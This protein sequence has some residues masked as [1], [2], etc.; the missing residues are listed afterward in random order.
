MKN[1]KCYS[2]LFLFIFLISCDVRFEIKKLDNGNVYF[3]QGSVEGVVLNK[4][5]KEENFDELEIKL[6]RINDI[7]HSF[8]FG[9]N[10]DKL[11]KE[12]EQVVEKKGKSSDLVKLYNLSRGDIRDKFYKY[13]RQYTMNLTGDH[14]NTGR[15]VIVFFDYDFRD[16]LNG[17]VEYVT[18]LGE[19]LWYVSIDLDSESILDFYL[20]NT[21]KGV[22]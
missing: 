22:L 1:F 7:I 14:I 18:G 13:K 12:M 19:K 4:E 10:K 6:T 11:W 9:E 2:L 8:I 17:S 21:L 16:W 20:G 15:I 5:I 3:K